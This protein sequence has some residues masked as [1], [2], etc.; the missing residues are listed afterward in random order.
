[1]N[2]ET[3]VAGLVA[4]LRRDGYVEICDWLPA[5]MLDDLRESCDEVRSAFTPAFIGRDAGRQRMDPVRGDITRWLDEARDGDRGFLQR[6]DELRLSLN[7]ALYLG[8]LDYECHYSIYVP[9]TRYEKH[10]DSLRG[11]RNRL[12]STVLYLDSQWQSSDG[13]ELILYAHDESVVARIL[14]QAGLLV[15]FLSEQFPHEVQVTHRKR[16]SIAGWF[17]GR[18]ANS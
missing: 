9:G 15:L 11:R 14:P 18:A 2:I 17:Q 4:G 10:L 12:L 7:A 5:Q 8:L 1:M 13:G 6:M 3:I 16:H